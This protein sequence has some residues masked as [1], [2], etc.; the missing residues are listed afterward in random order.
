M[1]DTATEAPAAYL[2]A[3]Q[4]HDTVQEILASFDQRHDHLALELLKYSERVMGNVGAA[5]APFAA[6]R[7]QSH[8]EIAFAAACGCA[9]ACD[10]IYRLRLAPNDLARRANRLLASVASII[11]PIAEA[12]HGD[13]TDEEE[14]VLGDIFRALM[15]D[16]PE[17]WEALDGDET[18]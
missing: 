12:G 10:M 5:E 7:R 2:L 9:A 18:R 15:D 8:Y 4:F 13:R 6:A 3:T 17:P 11:R 1:A 16:D 14:S